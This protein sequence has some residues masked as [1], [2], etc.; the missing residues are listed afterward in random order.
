MKKIGLLLLLALFTANVFA[1]EDYEYDYNYDQTESEYQTEEEPERVAIRKPIDGIY[2]TT[3]NRH[4]EPISYVHLREADAMW[5]K[6]IWR[7]I[8]L[9]EKINHP[10]HFPNKG[11]LIDPTTQGNWFSFW[12]V[13][14]MSVDSTEANPN[15]LMVYFDEFC[16]IPISHTEFLSKLGTMQRIE[17]RDPEDPSII[18]EVR[19]EIEPLRKSKFLAIDMKEVWFFEKQRSVLDVRMI[20]FQPMLWKEPESA[21]IQVE[22]LDDMIYDEVPRGVGW[23]HFPEAR[24]VLAANDAFNTFN[25]SERKTYDDIFWKRMFSSFVQ[26][27]ENIYNNRD[28][29]DFILNGMDQVL[30]SERITDE[31][32]KFEHN[33][34]DF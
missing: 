19:E 15:P 7:R 31:I 28:I 6:K 3:H 9:R 24:P 11:S 33:M 14:F 5:S 2:E 8:D 17:I 16:N 34:W 30:E 12:D 13:L 23:I 10:L 32:R 21:S 29:R 20:T 18:L 22:G 26:K 4:R 27:E 25:T 1:Q